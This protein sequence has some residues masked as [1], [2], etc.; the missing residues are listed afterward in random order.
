MGKQRRRSFSQGQLISVLVYGLVGFGFAFSILPRL[1]ERLHEGMSLSAYCLC[2]VGMLLVLYLAIFLQL[3]IH[4]AGH[5]VF[6]L[7]TGYGF[8]SFRIGSLMWLKTPQGIRLKR[9]KV[10]GTGGQCLLVPPAWTEQGIPYRLYNLGG[11]LMNLASVAV[12]GLL[13][14]VCR[15][16]MW[17]NCFCMVMVLC[18]GGLALTNGIPMRLGMV[19]ND[20]RNALSVG[21][22][23]DALRA[24]WV[25]LQINALQAQGLRTKDMPAELF[26]LPADADR[27]N[28][29]VAVVDLMACSRLMEEHRWEDAR[30]QLTRLLEQENVLTGLHRQMA[31]SELL[32]C[33]LLTGMDEEQ[34]Q[35]LHD[36]ALLKFYKAMK[37]NP[38]VLRTAYAWALLHEGDEA[39]AAKKKAAFEQAAKRYPYA[40]EIE[41]ERELMD[42]VDA[43]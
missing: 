21:K 7:A 37:T 36:E 18:G 2:V 41:M 23:P 5:L 33:G 38:A 16:H 31:R 11:V 13:A 40:Q 42:V 32:Y 34:L 10:A 43:A 24:L 25:Q 28:S 27:S 19:D 3:I 6:G 39:T 22:S 8:S 20:G 1:K 35:A 12:F 4:E 17:L 26:A 9:L 14:F 29:L 30:T 15:E